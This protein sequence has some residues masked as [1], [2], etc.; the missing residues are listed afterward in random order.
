MES[1]RRWG[2][3][4][5]LRGRSC[6][7]VAIL[8]GTVAALAACGGKA[9]R[10]PEPV[11]KKELA[12]M[13]FSVQVGAFSRIQNAVRLA[14]ALERRGLDAYYFRDRS[15]L[16]KVCFGNYAAPEEARARADDLV[17]AGVIPGYRLVGPEDYAVAG[18]RAYGIKG[19]RRQLVATAESFIGINYQWGGRSP[20]E[21]FDCSGLAMAVYQLNGLDL[22]RTSIEQFLAGIPVNRSELDLGDL[23]FFAIK[24]GRKVTHVGLYSGEGRFIHA[25]GTGKPIRSDE[26]AHSYYSKRYVGGRTYL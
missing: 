6:F 2:P 24:G 19:L 10:I 8:V 12:R 15:G 17:R 22:P 5:L 21:G 4:G 20:E 25:P 11:P 13:G 7:T 18:V 9:P 14:E 1:R 23:V 16:F 3:L 26:L